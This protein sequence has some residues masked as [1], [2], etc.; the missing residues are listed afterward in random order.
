MTCP[1]SKRAPKVNVIAAENA[2]SKASVRF[3]LDDRPLAQ[4]LYGSTLIDAK[5]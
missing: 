2:G 4:E 3:P 1:I 5:K